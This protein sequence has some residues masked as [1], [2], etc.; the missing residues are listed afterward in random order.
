MNPNDI[1]GFAE[2]VATTVTGQSL[3]TLNADPQFGPF[4]GAAQ[5]LRT[6]A[7]DLEAAPDAAKKAAWD[8][9]TGAWRA[10][11]GALSARL[12]EFVF[13]VLPKIPGLG[14]DFAWDAPQGL[15]VQAD[16]GPVHIDV[17]SGPLTVQPRGVP[18]PLTLGPFRPTAASASLAGPFPGGGALRVMDDGAS[19]VLHLALGVV[20]V[21]A[22]ASLRKLADGTP[23]FLAIVGVAFNPG[24]QLSFGFSI[25]R[26]GGI[27][28]VHRRADANGLAAA[29]RAGTAGDVLFS[30]DPAA[31]LTRLLEG[32]ER[33]FPPAKGHH[34]AGPTFE[35][36]WLKI[37][38]DESFIALDVGVIV[39]LPGPARIVIVG[40]A[41]AGIPGPVP[42]LKLRLDVLGVID[43][44]QRTIAF[45]ASL[46]DSRALGVFTIAGDAAFRLAYGA[47]PYTVLTL[48]GFYP[49]FNPE[50]AQLP[51]LRRVGLA[52]DVP[53]PGIDFRA[54]GY[55]AVTSN[56]LH[57][58]GHFECSIG[59]GMS[60]SGFLTVDALIQFR[61]FHFHADCSA[62]FD[63]RALGR[64]FAGVRLD[65]SIDG[66]G[67]IVVSG[68]L[69]IEVFLFDF[70]WHETFRIGSDGGETSSPP[71][72]L[73]AEL[74][75]ELS[76][77][78]NVQSG[79]TGDPSVTIV[80]RARHGQKALVSP[81]GTARWQ[82]RRA[83]LNLVI[84]RLEGK[85]LGAAQGVAVSVPGA[86]ATVPGLFS[87]GS[88]HTLTSSEAL[89]RPAFDLLDAGVALSVAG[90]KSG[91]GKTIA[92]DVAM[93]RRVHGQPADDCRKHPSFAFAAH[94]LGMLAAR[95][96][97]PVATSDGARVTV[98][99]ET[100]RTADGG[101]FDSATAAH[102]HV[103]HGGGGIA[104]ADADFAR[105]M[106]MAGL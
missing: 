71:I 84:E 46:V 83:P 21:S 38:P 91:P 28:G 66:P 9:A 2:S 30:A 27:V 75:P 86:F 62:G 93:I 50:P 6:A 65:G 98:T 10:A 23:S 70:S 88:Y 55:F 40:V 15:H 94:V 44:Q 68:R 52:L 57:L 54:D 36:G 3:A 79:D 99:H 103:R 29:L 101:A 95:D 41:R 78:E 34:L 60:A 20:D 77:P 100:W 97:T 16:V 85:P 33:M 5:Q 45:D 22:L 31:N 67:P 42:L 82:Q 8:E 12:R 104:L 7:A 13:G 14:D 92:A 39:E 4:L 64:T 43:F 51:A 59:E 105:P 73:L 87:P 49:G 17:V 72:D 1:V 19:G 48:G 80:A 58:G 32:V 63:V 90:Q 37:T 25:N 76:R 69:T 81:L 53:V 18:V 24:I 26:V 56:T 47:T 106:S 74:V 61:P 102:Q 89:N 11:C 96:A 35:I